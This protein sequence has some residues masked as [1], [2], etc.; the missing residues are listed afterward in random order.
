MKR[1]TATLVAIMIISAILTILRFDSL[2]LGTYGDDA[3]YVVTAEGIATGYGM[4]LINF[5]EPLI[6]IEFGFIWPAMLA[7]MVWLFPGNYTVLKLLPF[8]LWI[9]CI[10]LMY[11][12]FAPRLKSPYLEML[13][14]IIAINP[15]L[16]GSGTLVMAEMAY[17]LFSL[18]SLICFDYWY[19]QYP[20]ASNWLL[21]FSVI[22]VGSAQASR[23]VGLTLFIAIG[24]LL[25]VSRRF[26]PLAI[27]AVTVV[28]VVGV[29]YLINSS[30]GRPLFYGT[31]VIASESTGTSWL[32]TKI[33]HML[34]NA[35]E[36]AD[37]MV[38]STILD[39]F[40]P[41]VT[42]SLERFG[43]G[44]VPTILNVIIL[45]LLVTGF[46]MTIRVFPIG[47]LYVGGYWAVLLVYWWQNENQGAFAR[48]LFPLIP[49]FYYYLVVPMM[50][51]GEQFTF[52]GRRL[53]TILV[54]AM[55]VVICVVSL[56]RNVQD[57]RT[58]SRERFIDISAGR[59]WINQNAPE[60]VIVMSPHPFSDYLYVQRQTV[61]YPTTQ[62]DIADYIVKN[63]VGY[64][65]IGPHL[66]SSADRQLDSYTSKYLLPYIESHT[67]FFTLVYEDLEENV[68]VF[69]L[70]N[71]APPQSN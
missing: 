63:H 41:N 26:R 68:R 51:L 46:V 29:Q 57:W 45:G 23:P 2:Q 43:L 39:V 66:N 60:D 38:S 47:F 17:I 28:A 35:S 65:L 62:D 16:V 52:K 71:S 14:F 58:P 64:I 67:D 36:Y 9:I 22:T 33:D 30:Q 15:A 44:F 61:E 34:T 21:V 48:F 27:F 6:S 5:P 37:G 54:G 49:L 20:K 12:F 53:G 42:N 40:G 56:G 13:V 25:L 19:R 55:T 11:L 10:P 8:A 24:V 32:V 59:T 50:R 7:P 70:E 4:R 1:N 31:D 18:L 69:K 3:Y